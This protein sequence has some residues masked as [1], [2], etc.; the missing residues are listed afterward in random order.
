MSSGDVLSRGASAGRPIMYRQKS[1][2]AA[3]KLGIEQAAKF[4][5]ITIVDSLK[6]ISHVLDT[7]GKSNATYPWA[8]HSDQ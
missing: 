5:L 6:F 7:H 8:R 2:S 4:L 3:T 1:H